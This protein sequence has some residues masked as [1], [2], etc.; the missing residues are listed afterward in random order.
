MTAKNHCLTNITTADASAH[1]Q[2]SK[3]TVYRATTPEEVAERRWYAYVPWTW[4]AS[5]GPVGAGTGLGETG[6]SGSTLGIASGDDKKTF[7]LVP[8][9]IVRTLVV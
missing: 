7:L 9:K 4:T 2:E 3:S 8:S 6:S 1:A 5:T